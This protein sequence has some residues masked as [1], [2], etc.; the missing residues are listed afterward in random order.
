MNSAI[1]NLNNCNK[2]GFKLYLFP[3]LWNHP[4]SIV[5]KTQRTITPFRIQNA[6]KISTSAWTSN[7]LF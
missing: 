6:K 5:R 4:H 2:F 3:E 1:A 7:F